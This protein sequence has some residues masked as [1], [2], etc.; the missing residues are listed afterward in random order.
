MNHQISKAKPTTILH[1]PAVRKL[2]DMAYETLAVMI[3]ERKLK[4]GEAIVEQHLAEHLGLSR[5][6]LRQALQRLEIE[7]LLVKSG[8]RSYLV[9]KV[10]VAEYLQ[11]L[12]VREILEPEAAFLSTD[13]VSPR[14][15]HDARTALDSLRATQPY[16]YLEHL[17]CDDLVHE[18]FI[19]NCSNEVMQDTLRS[20]RIT[21]QLFEIDRLTDRLD[22]DSRE[23]DAILDALE[24]KDGKLVRRTVVAHIRSLIRSAIAAIA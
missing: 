19:R 14:E 13:R 7:G 6:P 4:S 23:H 9:R 22:P 17:K 5:T 16:D 15:L 3:R 1:R 11:S 18:L 12:R 21:T 24:Q 20:L 8:G 10:N 2:S